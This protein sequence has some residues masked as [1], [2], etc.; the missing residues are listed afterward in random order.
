M[1]IIYASHLYESLDEELIGYK[2]VNVEGN[3]AI[4]LFDPS[5][6]YDLVVGKVETGNIYLGTSKKFVM[7]Y[8]YTGSD[9]PE[10]PDEAI[11]TYKYK[12]SDVVKGNPDEKDQMSGGGE[13]VV[14]RAQLLS[15]Y[16]LTKDSPINN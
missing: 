1:N 14:K 15:A 9:E 6:K 8:Y 16:N 5:V 11:L 4:S 10:D 3:K 12:R 13:I 2:M 7:D